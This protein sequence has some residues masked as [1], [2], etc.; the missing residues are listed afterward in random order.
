MV[1]ET[2]GIDDQ[3][4]VFLATDQAGASPLL[5]EHDVGL[6]RKVRREGQ[7]LVDHGDASRLGVPGRARRVG[8]AVQRHRAGVGPKG[9]AEQFHERGLTRAVLADQGMHLAGCDRERDAPQ[10]AAGTEGFGHAVHFQ[11]WGGHGVS[12]TMPAP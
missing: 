4:P 3:A 10:R 8:Q 12:E 1:E 11:Q 7:L 9:A 2:K 5:A 6:D